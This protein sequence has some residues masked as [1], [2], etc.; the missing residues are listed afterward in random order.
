LYTQTIVKIRRNLHLCLN[1]FRALFEVRIRQKYEEYAERNF[2][3]QQKEKIEWV[4]TYWPRVNSLQ[5]LFF[6][7]LKKICSPRI[8]GEYT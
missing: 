7:Y 3:L 1:T 2:H 4:I 6:G 5:I 8:Y